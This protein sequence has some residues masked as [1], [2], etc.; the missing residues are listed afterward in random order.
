MKKIA[1]MILVLCFFRI[2]ICSAQEISEEYNTKLYF[3]HFDHKN[4]NYYRFSDKWQ[5][6]DPLDLSYFPHESWDETNWSLLE[7]KIDSGLYQQMVMLREPA[8]DL[9]I[10]GTPI[11][12]KYG[13]LGDFYLYM[14]MFTADT[15]PE[16][17][18]SCYVYYSDSMQKGFYTSHGIL[19]DPASGIYRTENSYGTRYDPAEAVHDIRLLK[20]L[21]A[22]DYA[23]DPESEAASSVFVREFDQNTEDRFLWDLEEMKSSYRMPGSPE[24]KA[25]R[26]EILREGNIIDVYINGTR[27][28]RMVD[29]VSDT[30]EYGN[31]TQ[32]L[33][34]WS[35]GPILYPEGL[36]ATCAV[37]DLYIYGKGK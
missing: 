1:F 15:Y 26:V 22:D 36:T 35:Y 7:Q 18:G 12:K 29:Y 3:E 32:N 16:G 24:V 8:S 30:D 17:S 14:T 20:P 2:P 10:Q 25:Y 37:G 33:V 27:V 4:K 9:V 34:S 21:N 11:D 19:I 5:I 28:V 23:F 6:F 13:F 31:E